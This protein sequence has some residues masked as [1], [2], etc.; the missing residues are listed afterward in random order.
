MT[1]KDSDQ[2]LWSLFWLFSELSNKIIRINI[3]SLEPRASLVKTIQ[4]T[5]PFW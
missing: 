4:T 3:K 2:P 5:V 1:I